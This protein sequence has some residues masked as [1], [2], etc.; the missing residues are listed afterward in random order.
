MRQMRE[1]AMDGG[2]VTTLSRQPEPAPIARLRPRPATIVETKLVPPALGDGHVARPELCAHLEALGRRRLTLITALAGFG[3]TRLVVE[4][5]GTT[6]RDPVAWVSLDAGDADP[7]RLWRHIAAAVSRVDGEPGEDG[8]SGPAEIAE[9]LLNR[10]SR[11]ARGM[12]IVLDD[13]HA[14]PADRFG[15]ELAPFVLRLPEHVRVIVAGRRRPTL[16]LSLLRARGELAEIGADALRL[17]AGEAVRFGAG[18]VGEREIDAG[19]R[20]TGAWPA[21]LALAVR[22]DGARHVREY[23]ADEV[24]AHEDPATVRFLELTAVLDEL[25]AGPCDDLLDAEDSLARLRALARATPLVTVVNGAGTRFRCEPLVRTILRDRLAE[26][27]PERAAQ[28]SARAVALSGAA[29][30]EAEMRV[31][32]LLPTSLTLRQIGER[33]Y[34]SLNTVKTHTRS[35]HRKLGVSCRSEAVER[36]RSLGML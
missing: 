14:V 3:K 28:L 26:R 19:V 17:Q 13:H 29:V 7:V 10:L 34:L 2:G 23:V 33:L 6:A 20:L 21:C 5:L 1:M 31:L 15:E 35:L 8:A 9:R 18:A 27:E 22:P 36:A 30:S 16:P 11:R 32:R 4:W 25:R 12:V 24:L